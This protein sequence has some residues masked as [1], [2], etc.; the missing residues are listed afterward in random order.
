LGGVNLGKTPLE[1]AHLT[2]KSH[3]E[4]DGGSSL[5]GRVLSL[6]LGLTHNLKSQTKPL[7]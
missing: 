6:Q 3:V 2:E 4:S 1:P 7:H 5:V